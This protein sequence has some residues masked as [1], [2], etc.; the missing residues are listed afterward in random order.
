MHSTLFWS[1]LNENFKIAQRQDKFK[2]GTD[3]VVLSFFAKIKTERFT[4]IFT[5][6]PFLYSFLFSIAASTLSAGIAFG[7][8]V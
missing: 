4:P 7:L 2:F 5:C 6:T 1:Q 3:A 8:I